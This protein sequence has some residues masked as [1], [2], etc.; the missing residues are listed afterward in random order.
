VW[1][2]DR[3][4]SMLGALTRGSE[5][6]TWRC[7]AACDDSDFV[8]EFACDEGVCVRY[9][10]KRSARQQNRRGPQLR[11]CLRPDRDMTR[12]GC[13]GRQGA[14]AAV[15]PLKPRSEER[16]QFQRSF[17]HSFI[18]SHRRVRG[19]EQTKVRAAAGAAAVR[20]ATREPPSTAH[21]DPLFCVLFLNSDRSRH[22]P[23]PCCKA[24]RFGSCA[25]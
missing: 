11:R 2:D 18:H 17:S 13:G 16:A 20:C 14:A 15:S 25:P 6:G 19:C 24:L 23:R 9:G 8:T 10:S 21:S 1:T 22:P 7:F 3:P 5:E 12:R 4:R